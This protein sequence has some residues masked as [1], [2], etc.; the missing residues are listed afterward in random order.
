MDVLYYQRR[1]NCLILIN[2]QRSRSRLDCIATY[3]KRQS[4]DRSFHQRD[5]E[6]AES[7]YEEGLVKA[8]RF[9][10]F[11]SYIYDRQSKICAANRGGR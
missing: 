10:S 7:A 8:F 5:D 6:S 9:R 3:Q 4:P 2:G 11:Y 1:L